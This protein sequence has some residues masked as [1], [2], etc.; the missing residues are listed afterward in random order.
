MR[1]IW[2][3]YFVNAFQGSVV[4]NLIPYITSNWETHSL[5]S[6]IYIVSDAVTA[7]CY[8][9]LGKL[10]DLWGRAEGFL[11]MT[12][13]ATVGLIMMAASNSLPL[14]SAAY[15]RI[16]HTPEVGYRYL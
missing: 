11:F 1:S 3:L 4:G 5:L 13:C 14:F 9:P 16:S 12:T 8:I 6:V 7:A 15:V 2:L 10:M